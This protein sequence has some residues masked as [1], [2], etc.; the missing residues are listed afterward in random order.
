MSIMENYNIIGYAIYLPITF[1]ITI[2][3]GY[4]C[5]KHGEHHLDSV[6]HGDMHLVKPV[7]NLLLVGYYLLNLGYATVVLSFWEQLDTPMEIVN[8]VSLKLG[9]IIL[10]L[11]LMHYF[12]LWATGFI[13]KKIFHSNQYV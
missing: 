3:V 13:A 10:G 8:S 9:I 6:F 4:L 2:W 12:N 5:H 7:N 11:G 1:Y